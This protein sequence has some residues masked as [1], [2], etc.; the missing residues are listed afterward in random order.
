MQEGLV[1]GNV[2]L[3]LYFSNAKKYLTRPRGLGDYFRYIHLQIKTAP[4]IV[5]FSPDHAN[6]LIV[7]SSL[8]RTLLELGKSQG[9]PW[10]KLHLLLR[11]IKWCIYA[12]WPSS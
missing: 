7:G 4:H 10:G 1:N 12:G 9:K 2:C 8:G 3:S 6:T 11:K 5:T